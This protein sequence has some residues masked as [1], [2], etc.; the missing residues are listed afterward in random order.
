MV[1]TSPSGLLSPDIAARNLSIVVMTLICR[2]S[3]TTIPHSG[4]A[5]HTGRRQ[6]LVKGLGLLVNE[7][8]HIFDVGELYGSDLGNVSPNRLSRS[9]VEV[10]VL[11][12]VLQVEFVDPEHV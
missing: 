1:G 11:P 10:V 3:S 12:D 6:N 7:M 9:I 5:R 2:S 8:A 4:V